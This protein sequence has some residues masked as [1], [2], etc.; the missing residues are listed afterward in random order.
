MISCD[1]GLWRRS[2]QESAALWRNRP[3]LGLYRKINKYLCLL[4]HLW[5]KFTKVHHT[6]NQVLSGIIIL[7]INKFLCSSY[8]FLSHNTLYN[9]CK[10]IDMI[11]IC[12]DAFYK[13]LSGIFK[14]FRQSINT[15]SVDGRSV[16]TPLWCYGRLDWP[17]IG[18]L[19]DKI[20]TIS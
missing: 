18:C 10:S 4:K 9:T 6:C 12:L 17:C 16:S 1:R 13:D 5:M 7:C 15:P 8:L 11:K 3:R 2:F 20:H 19:S 14:Y